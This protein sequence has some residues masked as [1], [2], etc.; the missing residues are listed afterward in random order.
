LVVAFPEK[1]KIAFLTVSTPLSIVQCQRVIVIL[2][3]FN[4]GKKCFRETGMNRYGSQKT[5]KIVL[6]TMDSRLRTSPRH[7]GQGVFFNTL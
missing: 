1:I 7:G 5:M 2:V 6:Y 3:A 4:S